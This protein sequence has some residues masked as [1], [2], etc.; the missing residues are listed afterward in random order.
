M[1]VSQPT[2]SGLSFIHIPKNAGTSIWRAIVDNRLPI[3]FG[4]HDYPGKL[5]EEEIVVLR[6]PIERFFSAFFYGRAYWPNAI[7]EQFADPDE[8]ATSAADADHPKH[9][10]ALTELGNRPQDFLRR[11]GEEKPQHT[12]ASK[13]TRFSWVYE[14]QSTWLINQPVHILRFRHLSDDFA[15]LVNQKG[16]DMPMELPRLNSSRGGNPRLSS[17]AREF[18]ERTYAADF[19]FIRSHALDV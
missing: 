1:S 16:L 2:S 4:D 5:S 6:D 17:A 3:I 12:V 11:N 8:L 14:P 7:S 10:L 19:D 15:S 9:E 18:L 13:P